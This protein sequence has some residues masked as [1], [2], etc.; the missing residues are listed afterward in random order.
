V[1][2]H[3]NAA[4]TDFLTGI[5]NGRAFMYEVKRAGKRGIRVA[6]I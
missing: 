5:S 2:Y 3:E 4:K 6:E 1:D